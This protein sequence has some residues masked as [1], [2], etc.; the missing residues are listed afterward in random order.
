MKKQTR[1]KRLFDTVSIDLH[2]VCRLPDNGTQMI[3]C[4]KCLCSFHAVCVHVVS[5]EMEKNL[6]FGKRVALIR[7]LQNTILFYNFL[8]KNKKGNPS[9]VYC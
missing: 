9:E 8:R 3:Q 4:D 2:C 5:D 1:R 7:C 6:G